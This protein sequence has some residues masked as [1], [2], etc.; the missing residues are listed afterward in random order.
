MT[1]SFEASSPW[2]IAED[3]VSMVDVLTPSWMRELIDGI[4]GSLI[5]MVANVGR[6]SVIDHISDYT[7]N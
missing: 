5:A 3:L 6:R 2:S 1:R 7:A 4:D